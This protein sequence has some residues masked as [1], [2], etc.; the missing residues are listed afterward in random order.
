MLKCNLFFMLN[1]VKLCCCRSEAEILPRILSSR[2][3]WRRRW[4][5]MKLRWFSE[6]WSFHVSVQDRL[7]SVCGAFR[8][9][10][11]YSCSQWLWLTSRVCVRVCVWFHTHVVSSGQS[12]VRLSAE[13]EKHLLDGVLDSWLIGIIWDLLRR[14][15]KDGQIT[16]IK[17]Q[18]NKN[19][20]KRFFHLSEEA[21]SLEMWWS[22]AAKFRSIRLI[23]VI[24]SLS[25][26]LSH[27][28]S[29][30]TGSDNTAPLPVLWVINSKQ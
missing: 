4:W 22:R 14:S 10:Q 19:K 1:H 13:E 8:D 20:S 6:S 25:G 12:R 17:K 16:L 21:E 15:D 26:A 30:K 11:T 29:W 24:Q 2:R 18:K 5:W 28:S 7:S 3:L 9:L 27:W 23:Q